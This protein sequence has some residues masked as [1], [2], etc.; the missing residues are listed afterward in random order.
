MPY[1][2][3]ADL[4]PEELRYRRA[5]GRAKY[6]AYKARRE[7]N[8][9]RKER[10]QQIILDR[11]LARIEGRTSREWRAAVKAKRR[12]ESGFR[13]EVSLHRLYERWQDWMTAERL[14]HLKSLVAME[15]V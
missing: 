1:R 2:R 9:T 14:L 12:L 11:R 10:R 13:H 7:A 15:A 5:W 4:T 8:P 3:V 6:A